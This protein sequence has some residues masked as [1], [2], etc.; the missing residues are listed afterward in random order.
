MILANL[1]NVLVLAVLCMPSG[2]LGI[3]ANKAIYEVYA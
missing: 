3:T 1:I 2:D